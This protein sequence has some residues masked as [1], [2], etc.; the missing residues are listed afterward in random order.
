MEFHQGKKAFGEIQINPSNVWTTEV[1]KIAEAGDIL[2]SVR[3]P[4]GP[5]NITNRQIC[6]GRGL[7]AIRC[8]KKAL[9]DFILYALRNIENKIQ[10]KD[11]TVFNS[12]NKKMIEDLPVPSKDISE[13]QRIVAYLDA[14]FAKIDALKAKAKENLDNAQALFQA[15]LKEAMT[16]QEGWV[17]NT[18]GEVCAKIGSGATPK[19]GRKV[20]IKEGCCLIRSK[21][22]QYNAFKYKDLACINENAACQL[23]GVTIE[24]DDVLFNI[25]GASIAR[26]CI[27]PDDVLPARVN[28]HVAIIRMKDGIVMPTFLSYLLNSPSHQEKLLEIGETGSTRQALTKNDLENHSIQFPSKEVQVHL[29]SKLDAM[30][31]IIKTL[32]GYVAALTA[33]CD[34]LKQAVLRQIFE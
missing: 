15:A 31:D 27:V 28:Q 14:T 16:P 6:I 2:M 32:E 24:K 1:T 4:V 3:A 13:Q 5:T 17:E 30:Q 33:E 21:N 9:P 10:G 11:G 25:T 7:A 18:L 29:V 22:V 12:M 23:K 34:A 19:G 8:S 26:C 20:Y